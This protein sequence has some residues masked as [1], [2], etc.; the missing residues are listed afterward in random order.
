VGLRADRARRNCKWGNG[1]A[2]VFYSS[3]LLAEREGSKLTPF[4]SLVQDLLN[5]KP[6]SSSPFLA[7]SRRAVSGSVPISSGAELGNRLSRISSQNSIN[8]FTLS[9]LSFS[10]LGSEPW[11][12][13]E[14]EADE[15]GRVRGGARVGRQVYIKDSSGGLGRGLDCDPGLG[16]VDMMSLR[17]LMLRWRWGRHFVDG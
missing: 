9:C 8:S 6:L 17:Q 15:L 4:S 16:R 10:S 11:S 7:S 1:E 13:R 14:E 5:L 12:K 2:S 3:A